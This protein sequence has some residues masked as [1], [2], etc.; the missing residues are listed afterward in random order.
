MKTLTVFGAEY[1]I[2][3]ELQCGGQ[4]KGWFLVAHP[5]GPAISTNQFQFLGS[6]AHP[7]EDVPES[8][9]MAAVKALMNWAKE[10]PT[11]PRI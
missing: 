10:Q 1:P 4:A 6:L 9:R 7:C 8:V 5:N 11:F 2:M 3:D